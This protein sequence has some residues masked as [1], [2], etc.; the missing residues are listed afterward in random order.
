MSPARKK[1]SQYTIRG[2]FEA[3][4]RQNVVNSEEYARGGT[5]N[6]KRKR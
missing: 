1:G 6:I 5:L 2:K 4:S 3:N